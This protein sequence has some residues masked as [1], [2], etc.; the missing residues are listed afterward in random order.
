MRGY[1]IP[2]FTVL[3]ACRRDSQTL[4]VWKRRGSC[5]SRDHVCA[6]PEMHSSL[7]WPA[8]RRRNCKDLSAVARRL[9]RSW[10][11]LYLGWLEQ[12]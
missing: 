2:S 12:F 11:T 5:T 7:L 3:R 4:S 8:V 6:L 10:C 9:T 1:E